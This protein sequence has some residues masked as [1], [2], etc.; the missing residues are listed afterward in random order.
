MLANGAAMQAI[1]EATQ[2]ETKVSRSLAVKAHKLSESMR[3]DSLSMRT[4][5]TFAYHY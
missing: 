4:V 3:K 2:E 5:G 1:M